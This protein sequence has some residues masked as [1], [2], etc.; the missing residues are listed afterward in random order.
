MSYTRL[1]WIESETPLSAQNMNNIEDGVEYA[2]DAVED[3][4][5]QISGIAD[6]IYPVGSIYMSVNSTDPSLLFGGTWERIQ[7]RF[8]LAAGSTYENGA[9]G[10]EATHVL[11]DAESGLKEHTHNVSIG[12]HS[13][14]TYNSGERFISVASGGAVN[15]GGIAGSGVRKYLYA[16]VPSNWHMN[17]NTSAADLGTKTTTKN[18]RS[19]GTAHNNMPPYLAVYIWKRTA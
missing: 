16:D 14:G 9:T 6:V 2:V 1:N 10:G 11:T 12:T 8:L 5:A 3:A 18:A 7:D 17:L 19:N 15:A 13:H 4:L